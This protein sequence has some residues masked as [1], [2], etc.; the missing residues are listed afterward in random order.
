MSTYHT[1]NTR[2]DRPNN[3]SKKR[4]VT[5]TGIYE[6]KVSFPLY[7]AYSRVGKRNP[8]VRHSVHPGSA[9]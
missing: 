9:E 3:F 8:E 2:I 6:K 1:H 5:K 7:L 4:I